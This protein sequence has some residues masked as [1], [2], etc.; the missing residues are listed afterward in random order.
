ML[1]SVLMIM[2]F[3]FITGSLAR[4]AVPGPDP[5]PVWLTMAI[6]LVGSAAGGA[7][8]IAF[9]GKGTQGIGIF[10]FLGAVILVVAYRRF[11]QKRPIVGPQALAFPEKGIGISRFQDRR[12][13]MEDML[14]QAQSEQART[15]V[16][17]NLQ[18]LRDLHEAGI[19]TDEEF[20]AKKA[21]LQGQ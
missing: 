21:H 6:G 19:L 1:G 12:Q 7:L 10:S 13:K 18:K 9:W 11:V 5:M 15:N 8:A 20:E 2:L 17:S 14:R 3:G 16:D 4:L